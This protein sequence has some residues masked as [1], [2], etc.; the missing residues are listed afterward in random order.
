MLVYS[1][2]G[3]SGVCTSIC[4]DGLSFLVALADGSGVFRRMVFGLVSLDGG[5]VVLVSSCQCV[6]IGS[7]LEYTINIEKNDPINL[8]IDIN[9]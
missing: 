8:Y 6:C 9:I 7:S 3:G 2:G 5:V 4:T 1:C